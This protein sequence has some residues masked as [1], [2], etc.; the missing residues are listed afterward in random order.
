[1][2]RG[3]RERVERRVAADDLL[4]E[5]AERRGRIE[6]QLV[7]QSSPQP[8]ICSQRVGPAT[9]PVQGQHELAR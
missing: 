1:M 6:S 5:P 4:L 2:T 9:G 7:G 3:S 8:A